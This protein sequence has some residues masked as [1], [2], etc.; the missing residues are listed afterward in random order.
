MLKLLGKTLVGL[1]IL[2]GLTAC[3]TSVK[4]LE[5]VET[6][7]HRL[8]GQKFENIS[9]SLSQEAQGKLSENP[10]FN[11]DEF[12][13]VVK[14]KFEESNL[15]STTS[16]YSININVTD[17]RTRSTFT[18]IMFG[19]MAGD[20]HIVGTVTVTDKGGKTIKSF[21]IS[22]SY[23]LGGLAGGQDS[24]RMNWLYEK[25]AELTIAELKGEKST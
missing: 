17:V 14:K 25:F 15:M 12:K 9:V 24:M 1:V 20:D 4:Q 19:F 3:A 18:A 21:E 11:S 7:T 13:N 22:A 16:E 5:T 8:T 2:V 23:A 6:E 10:T